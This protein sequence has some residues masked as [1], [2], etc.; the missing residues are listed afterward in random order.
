MG[1][2]VVRDDATVRWIEL[3]RPETLNALVPTDLAAIGEAVRRAPGGIKAVVIRGA[4][5]RAFCAGMHKKAFL[6]ASP[7]EAR[8]IISAVAD[9]LAAVRTAPLPTIAMVHGY[10]LGAGF[11]IA[12][13]CDLRVAA[14]DACFGLPEVKLGIPSVADAAL[15]RDHV[16]LSKAKEIILTGD[17]YPAADL[18]QFGL[19]N[20]FAGDANLMEETLVLLEKVTALTPE[21]VRAQKGLFEIWMNTGLQES[22]A[23]SVDVFA[24]MFEHS[25]TLEALDRY[26]LDG[27]A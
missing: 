13:S 11:E 4:G 6:D 18:Q 7:P 24:E 16:G 17:L 5:D 1:S 20:R 9:C 3:N 22:V 2:P 10:C 19:V 23:A 15:L 25:A 12:L 26:N 14:S 21:V 8:A 27:S